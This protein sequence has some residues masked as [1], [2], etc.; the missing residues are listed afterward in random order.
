TFIFCAEN[1]WISEVIIFAEQAVKAIKDGGEVDFDDRIINLLPEKAKCVFNKLK[2]LNLFKATIKKFENSETYNLTIEQNN[3]CKDGVDGCTDGKDI[4]NGNIK[5]NLRITPHE[6]PLN[7]AAA[8]LHEGI[9]AELFKYVDEYQKGL[10]P[11]KRKNLLGWYFIY[12]GY[13]SQSE[14]AQHQHMADNYV[15]PIAEAI[16]KLDN[17]SYP[18]EYYMGFGWDGLRKYGYDEY[19]DNGKLVSLDKSE[20]SEYNIKQKIVNDNTKLNGNE[21]K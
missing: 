18:L 3:D 20:A 16:R 15:K 2:G 21:C 6:Q 7:F 8:L 17:Y 19:Y 1:N 13:D 11:N 10:D 5:I 9:H 4:A 12:K 14:H